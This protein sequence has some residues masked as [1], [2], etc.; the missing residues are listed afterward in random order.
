MEVCSKSDISHSV[1]GLRVISNAASD[2][3]PYDSGGS[4]LI[5]IMDKNIVGFK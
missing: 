5:K 1:K 4:N 2:D 3:S